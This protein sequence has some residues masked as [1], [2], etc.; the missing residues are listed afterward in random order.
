MAPA[1]RHKK[2]GLRFWKLA[3]KAIPK[4]AP[5]KVASTENAA[6]VKQKPFP[7]DFVCDNVK[8]YPSGILCRKVAI[9]TINPSEAEWPKELG[10]AK[11]SGKS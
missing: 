5:R 4:I 10:M 7:P 8:I 1:A 2:I 3:S 6:A 11:P 9:T